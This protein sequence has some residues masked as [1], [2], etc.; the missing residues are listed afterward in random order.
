MKKNILITDDLIKDYTHIYSK[1]FKIDTLWN[2]RDK[3]INFSK[4]D[5]VVAS[6]LF[7]IT[8]LMMKNLS[9]IKI[10]SLFAVGYDNVDLIECKK[11]KITVANTPGVLTRDVADLALTLLL[12]IS[13]NIVTGQIYIK[14]NLWQKNGPMKLTDSIF[15]KKIG[16]VGLGK[17]G[18]EF[19]KKAEAL[20]MEVN[21]FGPRKKKSKYKYFKSLSHMA[22]YVDYLVITCAGG[23]E[24]KKIINKKVINSMKKTSYLIN[25]SRGTVIDETALLYSL[26]NNKIKGAALDVFMNEPKI[27]LNF[28]KLNNVI[29]H[30]HHGSGTIETRN[31]M[32]ELSCLNLI[33]FFKTGKP[34]HKVI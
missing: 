28:K 17:I 13:R 5:A 26:K 18:K 3:K 10:I 23:E 8:P 24:T 7:K 34:L 27:N 25:V 1:H 11:R 33:N 4:Y 14:S 2:I 29:L 9:N 32:A 19:A 16:I 21:Y 6:G 30:P 15:N 20:S 31:A 22:K 12:S